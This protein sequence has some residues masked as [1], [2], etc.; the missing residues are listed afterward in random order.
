M[1]FTSLSSFSRIANSRRINL[2]PQLKLS[3]DSSPS[4]KLTLSTAA[5]SPSTSHKRSTSGAA[6]YYKPGPNNLWQAH[7]EEETAAGMVL[8]RTK[9][10]PKGQPGQKRDRSPEGNGVAGPEAK[11]SKNAYEISMYSP[12]GANV[13]G[14]SSYGRRCS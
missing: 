3:F 11:K 1:R 12:G 6:A 13:R 4:K 10:E 7:H 9:E 2:M 8:K 5:S 14:K